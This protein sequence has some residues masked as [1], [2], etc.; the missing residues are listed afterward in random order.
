MNANYQ[1]STHIS[2]SNHHSEIYC[3]CLTLKKIEDLPRL[4][5]QADFTVCRQWTTTLSHLSS[6]T[7]VLRFENVALPHKTVGRPIKTQRNRIYLIC[8]KSVSGFRKMN[9]MPDDSSRSRQIVP[10]GEINAT[11][12]TP[13]IARLSSLINFP[14]C[15]VTSTRHTM[16]SWAVSQ[17]LQTLNFCSERETH[18]A[19]EV[20]DTASFRK[21]IQTET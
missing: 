7:D 14:V 18:T 10:W 19:S 4:Q 9:L 8:I 2:D 6:P 13:D 1:N 3:T 17:F 21:Q 16:S 20:W 12:T 11:V 5:G 15:V